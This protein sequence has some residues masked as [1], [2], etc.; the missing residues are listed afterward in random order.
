MAAPRLGPRVETIKHIRITDVND[1]VV[2]LRRRLESSSPPSIDD[3]M[4]YI[5]PS[6]YMSLIVL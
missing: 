3:S 2:T 4:Y 6:I 1:H 5:L